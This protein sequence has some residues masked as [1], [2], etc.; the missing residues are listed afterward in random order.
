MFDA[1]LGVQRQGS[2]ADDPGVAGP[3]TRGLD[4]DHDPPIG[5]LAGRSTPGVAHTVRMARRSDSARDIESVSAELL[6]FE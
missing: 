1:A 2:Q 3:E 6:I 4:V 5:R